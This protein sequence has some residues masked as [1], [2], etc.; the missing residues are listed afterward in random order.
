MVWVE[1]PTGVHHKTTWGLPW[2]SGSTL[3]P[4]KEQPQPKGTRTRRVSTGCHANVDGQW[5]GQDRQGQFPRGSDA[6]AESVRKTK[7]SREHP[8]P[9][10]V[11]EHVHRAGCVM[12]AWEADRGKKS[13][14]FPPLKP[15]QSR[16]INWPGLKLKNPP[17]WLRA[18]LGYKASSK[19]KEDLGA[20]ERE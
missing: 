20:V 11:P 8:T 4:P 5:P 3:H 18:G 10:Q 12:G 15:A 16:W 6:W 1:E 7:N 14:S 17:L 13:R 2:A 19:G 9:R